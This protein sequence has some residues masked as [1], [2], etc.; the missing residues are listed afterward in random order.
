MGQYIVTV[1]ELCTFK[2][3]SFI[4]CKVYLSTVDFKVKRKNIRT[5]PP[6][7][8]E[9]M[10]CLCIYVNFG[11]CVPSPSSICIFRESEY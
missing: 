1:I 9:T 5:Y 10:A 7:G 8:N 11:Q 3:G 4:V 2:M 6:L